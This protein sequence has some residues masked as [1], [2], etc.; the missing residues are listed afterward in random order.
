MY[1]FGDACCGLLNLVWHSVL[2]LLAAS[3][4]W[5]SCLWLSLQEQAYYLGSILGSLILGNVHI[6]V[7]LN[8]PDHL[9]ETRPRDSWKTFGFRAPM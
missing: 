8:I 9:I 3:I 7:S 1:I 2:F 5:G 4:N 6:A